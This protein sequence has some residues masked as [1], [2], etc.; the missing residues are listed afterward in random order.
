[1]K[2]KQ[3]YTTQSNCILPRRKQMGKKSTTNSNNTYCGNNER[4]E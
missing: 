2:Y 4:K 1:M 3:P